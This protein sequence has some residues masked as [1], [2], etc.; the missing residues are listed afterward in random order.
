MAIYGLFVGV[1][2]YANPKVS[3]LYGCK[4]DVDLI[5]R[6]LQARYKIPKGNIRVLHNSD[7]TKQAII[8]GFQQHLSKAGSNDTALFY[9]SGHGSQEKA[10]RSMHKIEEDG[11]NETLVCHDSRAAEPYDLADK[12]IRY[13][14]HQ[15]SE[16]GAKVVTIFDTCHSGDATRVLES[17][18]DEE[19][20]RRQ[21]PENES[22]RPL[23][24]YLFSNDP[25]MPRWVDN[26]RLMPEGP[27]IALGACHDEELAKERHFNRRKHGAFTYAL[28]RKLK[29]ERETPSYHNLVSTV[30]QLLNGL[31]DFQTPQLQVIGERNSNEE[32]LGTKLQA[33]EYQVSYESNKWWLNAG[34]AQGINNHA[35]LQIG[36]GKNAIDVVVTEVQAEQSLLRIVAPGSLSSGLHSAT[37]VD[38]AQ[39]KLSVKFVGAEQQLTAF[40]QLLDKESY[41]FDL[42]EADAADY[43]IVSEDTGLS[44]QRLH[45]P[46]NA[47]VLAPNDETK[48]V[49]DMAK[50]MAN[51]ERVRQLNYNIGHIPDD[52]VQLFIE[53]YDP[54]TSAFVEFNASESVLTLPYTQSAD[55]SYQKPKVRIKL[56]LN[57][58]YDW[59]QDVYVSLLMLDPV[60]GKASNLLKRLGGEVLRQD[61]RMGDENQ[62]KRARREVYF[63][64]S[65]GS[66]DVTFS[67][68]EVLI[69][70]NID[71]VSDYFKLFVSNRPLDISSLE[72]SESLSDL[73][74][75]LR[76]KGGTRTI[77]S[78]DDTPFYQARTQTIA[79]DIYHPD[80]ENDDAQ[81]KGINE[82]ETRSPGVTPPHPTRSA[83]NAAVTFSALAP[84]SLL[85]G[86]GYLIDIW[87]HLPSQVKVVIEA[88]RLKHQNEVAGQKAGIFIPEGTVLSVSLNVPG[89]KI[90]DPVDVI[91]WNGEPANASFFV[92]VPHEAKLIGKRP[93]KAKIYLD[94]VQIASITL[95]LNIA[96]ETSTHVASAGKTH[97]PRSAFVS[98][99]RKNTDEV[100]ARLQGIET[101]AKNLDIFF[102]VK[103]LRPGDRWKDELQKNIQNKDVFYLFWSQQA[104]ASEWVTK[105]WKLALKT[106]GLDYIQPVPLQEPSVAPPPEELADLHFNDPW[107]AYL[108]TDV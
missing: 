12:E 64:K 36:E 18:G 25:E 3:T 56:R 104:A 4:N 19:T 35:R 46:I 106:R 76:S 94:G 83:S 17:E 10:D 26:F 48:L 100:R 68:P 107:L 51:W 27:H 15:L 81:L 85:P 9:F 91:D 72:Q 8:N 96:Y 88:A 44:L 22:A 97:Y 23:D 16:R 87:A 98:Y 58:S 80:L 5:D 103:T 45:I 13:L 57:M 55:G 53:R 32:F 6:T 66:P 49:F 90:D 69:K 33:V 42:E 37:M 86:Q 14:I 40:R 63:K 1:N 52:L 34:I 29:Y 84:S 105:E 50:H 78:D 30:K 92:E 38:P 39:P 67:L 74:T 31:I 7:A 70:N 28:C 20:I 89:L 2:E 102:D 41:A 77:E 71:R 54:E 79:V 65:S 95:Q 43:Q 24:S 60:E 73:L 21:S 101:V 75:R 108:K 11:Y 47:P 59:P 99:S 82:E 61:E 62:N 93:G